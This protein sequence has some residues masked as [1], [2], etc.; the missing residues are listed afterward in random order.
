MDQKTGGY[1]PLDYL[2]TAQVFHATDDFTIVA[3]LMRDLALTLPEH[4]DEQARAQRQRQLVLA[5]NREDVEG[6]TALLE[7]GADPNV[8]DDTGTACLHT[9]HSENAVDK[10]PS[11]VAQRRRVSISSPAIGNHLAIFL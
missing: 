8:Q 3:R 6:C 10:G 2:G 7:A 1:V 4:W 9:G 11:R 5:V